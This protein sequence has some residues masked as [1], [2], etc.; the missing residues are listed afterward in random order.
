M[1]KKFFIL[2]AVSCVL[3]LF[4]AGCGGDDTPSFANADGFRYFISDDGSYYQVLEYEGTDADV[5]IPDSCNGL[6]VKEIADGAFGSMGDIRSIVVPESVEIIGTRAFADCTSL[7]SVTL[8]S[9]LTKISARTFSNCYRLQSIDIP[10]TVTEI[11]EYAFEGCSSLQN[12]NI[13]ASVK[14]IEGFLFIDCSGLKTVTFEKG[15]Q[16]THTKHGIFWDCTSLETVIFEENSLLKEITT[17]TFYNCKKLKNVSFASDSVLDC[18][19][20]GAFYHCLELERITIPSKVTYIGSSAF[21]NCDSLVSIDLPASLS[22][23]GG[24]AFDSCEK[25]SAVYITDLDSWCEIDFGNEY[26][27]PMRLGATLYCNGEPVTELNPSDDVTSIKAYSFYNCQTLQ[28]VDLSNA[29]KI[30]SIGDRAFY[31]CSNLRSIT[32]AQGGQLKRIGGHVFT[33]CY[34]L[35]SI[36]LPSSMTSIDDFTFSSCGLHDVVIPNTITKIGKY[37]FSSCTGIQTITIPSSVTSIGEGAFLNCYRLAEVYNLS[38]ITI[39][40]G[41]RS[42]GELG[43]H[44][45]GIYTTK[46]Q[47]S[48]ISTTAD[49]LVLFSDPDAQFVSVVDYVGTDPVVVLPTYV[50]AINA[51]AFYGNETIESI[52]FYTG[53][54]LTTIGEYAF[55]SCTNLMSVA[56]PDTVTSVA[57]GA[58]ESCDYLMFYEY[59]NAYYLGNSDNH[60]H[61]LVKAKDLKIESCEINPNTV[62]IYNQAFSHCQNLTSMVIPESVS[63]I[64]CYAFYGCWNLETFVF[65]EIHI[66]NVTD[67]VHDWEKKQDGDKVSVVDSATIKKYFNETYYKHYWYKKHDK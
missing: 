57:Y 38:P 22:S 26:S 9:A 50:T 3:C 6:P 4:L 7:E 5:V 11:G 66:W 15:S 19:W 63:K 23:I 13:P 42:N 40:K 51:M 64:S 65:D 55:L 45:L 1:K 53:S 8:P 39:T 24:N 17:E 36:E 67:N 14:N 54:Q 61:L 31:D 44:A 58:F 43:F 25:L 2:L 48:K 29:K 20:N 10:D 47:P 46:N 18:I 60:Y 16:I 32:F 34:K 21:W 56:I 28:T 37:A 41:K 12:V 27:N 33:A 59:D 52:T 62:I 49:G 35:N 30:E